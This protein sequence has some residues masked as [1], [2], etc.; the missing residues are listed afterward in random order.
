MDGKKIFQA[1]ALAFWALLGYY[2]Y[3][4]LGITG[5]MGFAFRQ[6]LVLMF[7]LLTLLYGL[8]FL[9]GC[10]IFEKIMGK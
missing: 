7:L 1:F 6:S 4:I 2:F 3:D 10:Y 9:L 8:W 5:E